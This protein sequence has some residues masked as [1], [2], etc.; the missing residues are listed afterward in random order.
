MIRT[1][2]ANGRQRN[3]PLKDYTG[4]RWGRL[5]A[6]AFL[7][8]DPKWASHKWRFVCD[9]GGSIETGI[10]NVTS[11]HTASCGCL[12][13]ETMS[14]RNVTHGLSQK[15]RSEYK[16]WKG[17]RQ[18]CLNPS[19]QDYADYG[20]RGIRISSAWDDFSVFAA[21]M[22]PRHSGAT[23]DRIDVNGD[24]VPENCRW[25]TALDQANNKR[26]NRVIECNGRAQTLQQWC[27]EF[28]AERSKVRY[29]L[30]RGMPLMEALT[31][32]DLRRVGTSSNT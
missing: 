15:M 26:T 28:G 27:R 17:M 23:L 9:C 19:N 16:I 12:F 3:R 6:V 10:K 4:Q 13:R 20:G 14:A 7:E 5:T 31:M 32:G 1:E 21:D 24:Y 22:G 30:S 8:R 18:R 29:R 2:K 25:A 11:G